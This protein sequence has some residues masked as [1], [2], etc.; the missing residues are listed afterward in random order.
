MEHQQLQ[1]FVLS[2]PS[3]ARSLSFL[4]AQSCWLPSHNS[5]AFAACVL[6]VPQPNI[7]QFIREGK[8]FRQFYSAASGA[9]ACAC[10]CAC[11]AN[12]AFA[13]FAIQRFRHANPTAVVAAAAAVVFACAVVGYGGD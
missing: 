6:F 7:D 2:L 1:R 12:D 9:C 8:D 13:C 11:V 4:L 10:A 5:R 3:P